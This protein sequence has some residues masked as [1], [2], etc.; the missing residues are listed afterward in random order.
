MKHLLIIGCGGFAREVYD[1]ACNSVGYL[2]EYDIKGFLQGDVL[3]LE[4]EL[5]LLPMPV[6]GTVSEYNF[7]SD[8][9]CICGIGSPAGRQKLCQIAIERGAAFTNVIHKYSCVSASAKLGMG[10]VLCAFSSI[11]CN[12]V[13]GN[14]V[15]INSHSG[16]GHDSSIGDYSVISAHCDLTGHVKV[17]ERTFFGGGSRALPHARVGDD[18]YIGA[19]SV[20]F[21]KV[22][23]GKK[24]FGNP[25]MEV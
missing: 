9:V 17:G 15:A 6:L 13:V 21:K 7:Q 23:S 10:I 8:E 12:T 11:S 3:L 4:D 5:S 14:H 19:S 18:A 1:T 20:V 24:V 16:M 22:K 25:A 2:V